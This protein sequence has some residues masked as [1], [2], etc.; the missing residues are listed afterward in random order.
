VTFD[1]QG[2]L[3]FVPLVSVL[4]A[5]AACTARRHDT[6][7]R[8]GPSIL[9]A[10]AA[11]EDSPRRED[12]STGAQADAG[13][14]P[15]V[16]L[17]PRAR[18]PIKPTGH[19]N[20][21]TWDF[22]AETHTLRD[23]EGRGA[24]PVSEARFLWGDGQLYVFFYAGDLDLQVHTTKHDG[25][26]WKGDSVA[27]TFFST[28]GTKHVIQ[29]SPKGTVADGSCPEDASD[30]GDPRCDLK[31]ESGARVAADYDGTINRVHDFD[32]EWVVEA[33]VPL[34]SLSLGD[35]G[36]G[37]SVRLRISRCEI[38]YDGQLACGSWGGAAGGGVLVFGDCQ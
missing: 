15:A 20:V 33:A 5:S 6:E 21:K 35:A 28:D 22:A 9:L 34:A 23:A 31:W 25:P 24:V 8:A 38:A 10:D 2:R 1:L 11:L 27:L 7:Q 19:F 29:I 14:T 26:V 13:P 17:V 12:P 32:E 16:L 3:R 37:T 4:A 36:V 30:L 18:A